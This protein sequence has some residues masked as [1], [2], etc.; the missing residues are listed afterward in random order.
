MKF[1][2]FARRER[3]LSSRRAT[4]ASAPLH[5]PAGILTQAELRRI[6]ADLIG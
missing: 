1:E 4:D 6:V 3:A 5:L 2:H